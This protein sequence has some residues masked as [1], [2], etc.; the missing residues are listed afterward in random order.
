LNSLSIEKPRKATDIIKM[1]IEYQ[2]PATAVI[3]DNMKRTK[4]RIK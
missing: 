1:K 2:R 4:L 3:M